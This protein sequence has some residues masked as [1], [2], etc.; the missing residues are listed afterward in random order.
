M[1]LKFVHTNEIISRWAGCAPRRIA[2]YFTFPQI[3]IPDNVSGIGLI[4]A[5]IDTE[6][7]WLPNRLQVIIEKPL[8]YRIAHL[9]SE[10]TCF[11]R[12][13]CNPFISVILPSSLVPHTKRCSLLTK[14]CTLICRTCIVPGSN[15]PRY[16]PHPVDQ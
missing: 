6:T 9:L 10:T 2:K 3:K 4:S 1:H 8:P 12:F 11:N 7:R 15:P 14:S 16:N 5:N 13:S